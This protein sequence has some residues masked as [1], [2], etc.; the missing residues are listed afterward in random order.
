M[1]FQRQA[2]PFNEM[3]IHF[4]QDQVGFQDADAE[5]PAPCGLPPSEKAG[6]RCD[7]RGQAA[8]QRRLA[9]PTV[10]RWSANVADEVRHGRKGLHDE[11]VCFPMGIWACL[12]KPRQIDR[13]D[14]RLKSTNGYRG[15][16]ADDDDVCVATN[17]VSARNVDRL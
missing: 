11:I 5:A 1:P 14:L 9:M 4:A 16:F 12:A 15:L 6:E 3:D 7:I 2:I 10:N 8:D 17:G 13:T